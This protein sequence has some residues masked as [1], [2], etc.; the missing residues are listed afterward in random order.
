MTSFIWMVDSN[1]TVDPVDLAP[2]YEQLNINLWPLMS[3]Y[4]ATKAGLEAF[5]KAMTAELRQEG[6]RVSLFISGRTAGTEFGRAFAGVDGAAVH[7]RWTREGYIERIAGSEAQD[8][9]WM[10]EALLFQVTRPAGQMI[11]IM[12]VRAAR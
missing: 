10:A 3:L 4:V 6:I 9:A 7:E 12:Q 2:Y 1:L 5:T 8:A 11:D